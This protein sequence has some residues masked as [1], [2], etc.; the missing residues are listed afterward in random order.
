M[1]SRI[2]RLQFESTD[3][4][5]V[6][7]PGRTICQDELAAAV[8]AHPRRVCHRDFHLNNLYLLDGPRVGLIDIQDILVGP[9]TYDVVSLTCERAARRLLSRRQR[10]DLLDHELP[11]RLE[12]FVAQVRTQDHIRVQGER[13]R[14]VAGFQRRTDGHMGAADRAEAVQSE[15]VERIE[16]RSVGTDQVRANAK[17]WFYDPQ[18]LPRRATRER[19]K[20]GQLCLG[21]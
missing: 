9:D 19:Q 2:T 16:D 12:L 20:R 17:L 1:L 11:G 7:P 21:T 4:G 6:L 10:Q 14:E 13:P 15:T 3:L 8:A 5:E 18:Q